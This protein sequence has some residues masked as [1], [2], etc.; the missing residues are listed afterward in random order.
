MEVDE[1]QGMVEQYLAKPLPTNWATMDLYQRRSYLDGDE[2]TANTATEPRKTVSNAEIWCECFGKNL[3]DMKPSDS[4]AIAALMMQID[5]WKRSGR[6][7]SQP[8]YGRQRVYEFA[9]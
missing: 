1:R 9:G 8:L 7:V 2:L 3:A 6:R 4:F 5:G